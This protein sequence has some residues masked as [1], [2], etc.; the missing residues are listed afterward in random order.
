M[1][2]V[3]ALAAEGYDGERT[4]LIQ[5]TEW[6]IASSRVA[7]EIKTV[8]F[9]YIYLCGLEVEEPTGLTLEQSVS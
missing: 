8:R 3:I 7:K 5:I 4:L 1:G 2:A 9:D 6:S